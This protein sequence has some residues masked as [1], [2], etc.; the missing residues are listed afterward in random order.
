MRKAR[1]RIALTAA[2]AGTTALAGCSEQE[3]AA[4]AQLPERTCFEVF[5]RSDLAPLLG[6]G[7]V[8]KVSA[9]S[10]LRLTAE[11]RGA[12]CTVD[13]DGRVSFVA[14]ATRQPLDQSFFWNPELIKPAPDPLPLGEK[15]IVYDTGARVL[16]VCRGPK[17]SFQ[18][19]LSLSGSIDH[20]GRGQSRP[21]FSE[22]MRKFVPVATEQTTCGS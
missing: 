10:D 18:V 12:T 1:T 5:T 17:D 3:K 4:E 19:E 13:V 7:D 8:V 20:V 9:P 6:N 11:R 16:L 21:L 22:L 2:L 15:G 14:S